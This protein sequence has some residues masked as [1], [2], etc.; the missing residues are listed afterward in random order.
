MLSLYWQRQAEGS[1]A[2]A[3]LVP[4]SGSIL[5]AKRQTMQRFALLLLCKTLSDDLLSR[6][7]MLRES[8]SDASPI[9]AS[10]TA[11]TNVDGASAIVDT[12]AAGQDAKVTAQDAATMTMMGAPIP[13]SGGYFCQQG[14]QLNDGA[15]YYFGWNSFCTIIGD[16]VTPLTDSQKMKAATYCTLILAGKQ[17][18]SCPRDNVV[19]YCV[20]YA[21]DPL[22]PMGTTGWKLIYQSKIN[23]EAES[24]AANALGTCGGRL[25]DTSGKSLSRECKGT[26]TMNVDGQAK[27]FTENRTCTWKSDGGAAEYFLSVDTPTND[28]LH[29]LI[30]K[31]NGKYTF[32]NALR[33]QNAS[34]LDGATMKAFV[35]P[36]DPGAGV[37]NVTKFEAKGAG[38]TA[39]LAPGVIKNGT[40][41]RAL[42]DGVI[43]IQ[44]V[45]P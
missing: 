44:I 30:K 10:A 32:G 39:T 23:A 21:E 42:T 43:D 40:T 20:P 41:S 22:F 18:T 2:A 38:L 19:A 28:R 17:V 9:D 12:A 16:G 13:A 24:V 8:N 4:Q 7:S 14:P 26:I 35:V 45:S 31:E 27:S 11:D 29:V 15:A 36:A 37:L 3:A 25:Y 33:G 1:G 34:Y 5:A 6:I